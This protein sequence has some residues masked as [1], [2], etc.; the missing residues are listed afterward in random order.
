MQKTYYYTDELNDDFA[1]THIETKTLPEDYN[2]VPKSKGW[3]VVRLLV[4]R[5]IVT[6]II[7]L[8]KVFSGTKIKN[9]QVLKPYKKQ[10]AYIY[11]NHTGYAN[12][13]F[14]PTEVAF[15]RTADIVVNPDA[16]SIKFVGGIVKACGGIPVPD[17]VRGLKRF[18]A[19]LDYAIENKH[20]IAIYPEAHIWPYY[21][22]IRPYGAASFKYPAKSGTPVFSYTTVHKKR[23]F[24]KKP[25]RVVYIDGP[26]FADQSLPLK[27]RTQKLRDEVYAAMCERA[28]LT[29]KE[30]VSYVKLTD[31]HIADVLNNM[32]KNKKRAPFFPKKRREMRAFIDEMCKEYGVSNANDYSDYDQQ[33]AES[34]SEN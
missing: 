34:V 8:V 17:S 22:G 12:D 5:M 15:P 3:K 31:P 13:A 28:K 30:Y 21:T 6:P 25:R 4:Y 32:Q 14:M 27:Q 11:G 20:W 26:F 16:V 18:T 1:N 19:D 24:F 10:G 23:M 2:F 7:K 33:T 29:T 9:K